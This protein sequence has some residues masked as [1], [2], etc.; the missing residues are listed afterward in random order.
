MIEGG[1]GASH[2]LLDIW[3]KEVMR[4]CSRN[5]VVIPKCTYTLKF[6]LQFTTHVH[7]VLLALGGTGKGEGGQVTQQSGMI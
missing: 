5:I 2:I 3:V 7:A 1:R 4:L 6:S